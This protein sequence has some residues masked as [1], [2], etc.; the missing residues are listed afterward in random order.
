M[1]LR[2]P[3]GANKCLDSDLFGSHWIPSS[4]VLLLLLCHVQGIPLYLEN[5]ETYHL[6]IDTLVS[7][8]PLP[9]D[10]LDP[11]VL[12]WKGLKG[13]SHNFEFI[14]LPRVQEYMTDFELM[15]W[16]HSQ[17]RTKLKVV[18]W[19][20]NK[21]NEHILVYIN[22]KQCEIIQKVQWKG[23]NGQLQCFCKGKSAT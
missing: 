18:K 6:S 7:T 14:L 23:S 19:G 11:I 15:W 1:A 10:Q 20:G 3:G 22:A 12:H 13:L 5:Q 4:R 8:L 2:A 9:P 21:W 17:S 16:K